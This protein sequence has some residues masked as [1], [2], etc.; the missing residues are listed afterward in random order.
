MMALK[1]L[2]PGQVKDTGSVPDDAGPD[3]AILNS[4]NLTLINTGHN[5]SSGSTTLWLQKNS[6]C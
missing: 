4:N 2:T 1:R 3:S 6:T 5:G